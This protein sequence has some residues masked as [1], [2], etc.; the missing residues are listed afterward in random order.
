MNGVGYSTVMVDHD[1]RAV[2]DEAMSALIARGID[3]TEA[4]AALRRIA[5]DG[6]GWS[7]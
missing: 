7:A 4:L 6:N 3:A 1:A 5:R 2:F